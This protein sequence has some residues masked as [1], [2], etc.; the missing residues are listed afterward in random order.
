MSVGDSVFF[1]HIKFNIKLPYVS[2][3][4]EKGFAGVKTVT[5]VAVGVA[6]RRCRLTHQV[7][8]AC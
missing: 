2:P 6:R 5:M 1:K 4:G 3:S 8:P 7:D